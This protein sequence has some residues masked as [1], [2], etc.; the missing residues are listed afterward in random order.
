MVKM[1]VKDREIDRQPVE[2]RQAMA[3]EIGGDNGKPDSPYYC[4]INGDLVPTSS[5]TDELVEELTGSKASVQNSKGI[6]IKQIKDAGI[7]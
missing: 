2:R 3:G 5:N 6:R 7:R 1:G 4:P